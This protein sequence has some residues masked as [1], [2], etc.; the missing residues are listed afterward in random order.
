[1]RR[2][3]WSANE[4]PSVF[5]KKTSSLWNEANSIVLENQRSIRINSKYAK[6]MLFIPKDMK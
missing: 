5:V 6:I 2:Y 1:M 4:Q 3:S